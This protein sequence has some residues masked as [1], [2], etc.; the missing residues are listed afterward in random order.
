MFCVC[1]MSSSSIVSLD[2]VLTL[3]DNWLCSPMEQFS[4]AS[5]SCSNSAR[6]SNNTLL[7]CLHLSS[8]LCMSLCRPRLLLALLSKKRTHAKARRE[9]T[10]DAR[11]MTCTTQQDLPL[12]TAG[13]D[14]KECQQSFWVLE[15]CLDGN[16]R[17][18]RR[19]PAEFAA[20][21]ECI[22]REKNAPKRNDADK[23]Q[24]V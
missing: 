6:K 11:P 13:Q 22:Q 9:A 14:D 5:S 15:K 19:C 8:M 10:V 4:P 18:Y 7:A 21:K 20:W 2:N 23:H 3:L 17:N 16:G 24:G 12:K 1:T